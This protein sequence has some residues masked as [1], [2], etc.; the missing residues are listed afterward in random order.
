MPGFDRTGPMGKGS[1]TGR[2]QGLCRPRSQSTKEDN[3]GDEL[4]DERRLG[5]RL[6]RGFR[7][8]RGNGGGFGRRRG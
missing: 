5:L 1:R 6:G 3:M 4:P 2:G 7:R 8:G